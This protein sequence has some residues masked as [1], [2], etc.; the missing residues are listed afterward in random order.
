MSNKN[1]TRHGED[2]DPSIINCGTLMRRN[3]DEVGYTPFVGILKTDCTFERHFLDCSKDVFID[4]SEVDNI[5]QQALDVTGY[6]R[7]LVGMTRT[8]VD[9]AES[10]KRFCDSNNVSEGVRSIISEA[11]EKE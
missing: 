3:I 4:L 5:L 2:D 9:F 10:V 11:M 1:F 7:E 6:M 8:L